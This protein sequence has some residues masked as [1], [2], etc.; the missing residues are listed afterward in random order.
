MFNNT[1]QTV[2]NTFIVLNEGGEER[3]GGEKR[4]WR[5]YEKRRGRREGEM[6]ERGVKGRMMEN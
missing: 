1:N 3:E 6:M 2:Y 5:D 4:L